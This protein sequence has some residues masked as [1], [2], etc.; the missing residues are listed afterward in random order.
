[1]RTGRELCGPFRLF[2]GLALLLLASHVKGDEAKAGE[3]AKKPAPDAG[4]C[5]LIIEGQHIESLTFARQRGKPKTIQ[6]PGSTVSLPAGRYRLERVAL[7]GGFE[8][9]V[10]GREWL[11][12]SADKPCH[13]KVGAPL[14]PNV[15]VS[16]QGRILQLSYELLDANGREYVGS[17]RSDP[18]RF[19]VYSGDRVVGSGDFEYG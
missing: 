3:A 15:E 9:Y 17:D 14:T 10:G 12:L 5:Q 6:R 11:A 16:R 19:T 2:A 7:T 1:M 13:L 18:P 4:A 8:C